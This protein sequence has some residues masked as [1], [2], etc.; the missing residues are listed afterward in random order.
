ML[1]CREHRCT[2]WQV[3]SN[4]NLHPSRAQQKEYRRCTTALTAC[5]C[6]PDSSFATHVVRCCSHYGQPADG[7]AG[8]QTYR[9]L[10]DIKAGEAANPVA[11]VVL[12]QS[13]KVQNCGEALSIDYLNFPAGY[14]PAAA[15]AKVQT[16][17][18]V[19][20]PGPIGESTTYCVCTPALRRCKDGD[21][22]AHAPGSDMLQLLLTGI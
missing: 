3:D 1:R 7:E 15:R 22:P 9:A 16:L 4:A 2:K 10:R 14:C 13:G 20:T 21:F 12:L 8:T 18:I 19:A 6:H 11:C 17:V 5:M